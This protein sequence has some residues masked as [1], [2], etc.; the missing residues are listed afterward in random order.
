[1]KKVII[2]GGGIAGLSAG[3]HAQ[4][5]GYSTVIYEKNPMVGGEC[6]GWNRQ[7]YHIDNCI[8]W[9]TGAGTEGSLRRLWEHVGALAPDTPLYREDYLYKLE[10]D[11]VTL[12]FWRDVE[13]ARREFLEHAPEDT[14]EINK[15]FDSVILA[16]CVRVPCEKSQADMNLLELAKFG[17][18]MKNMQKVM[19]EYGQETVAEL[20]QRFRNPH[21]R[22]MM[23]RYFHR[24]YLAYTLITSYAFLSGGTGAIPQGGSVGLVRRI[25]QRYQELGGTILTNM[26]A[27]KIL[28]ENGRATGVAFADGSTELCDYVICATDPHVT[29]TRLLPEA[30]MDKKL[31]SMYRNCDGYRVTSGFNV[32]FGIAGSEP[33]SPHGASIFPCAPFAVGETVCEFLGVRMYDYDP[34]L[35]PADKRVLQCNILQDEQDYAYWEGLHQDKSRYN[36]EKQRIARDVQQ[37]ITAQ[38]PELAGRLILLSTYSP[39]T[40]TKWCG[41]YKGAYM[42]FLEQKGSKSIVVRNTIRALPNVLLAGQWLSTSGGLPMALTTGKFAAEK[43]PALK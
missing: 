42:S 15:F 33:C 41:A 14:R 22:S 40:F 17:M 31:A 2:I 18:P 16:E 26:S 8:H 29:F 9:L 3:I 19:K 28:I 25:T 23:Q 32:S 34:E 37:R 24:N 21:V 11:G 12:H 38:Y 35:F 10:M 43:L 1:M 4:E 39:Y 7:G 30:Y 6:T 36:A 13:K 20:A 27:E 5:R